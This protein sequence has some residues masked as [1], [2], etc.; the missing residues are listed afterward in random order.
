[1]KT[2]ATI[3]AVALALNAAVA[4]AGEIPTWKVIGLPVTPHQLAV[5]GSLQVQER[6]PVR[7]L[8]LGGMPASPHQIAVLT[9]RQAAARRQGSNLFG[10]WKS[11]YP[12]RSN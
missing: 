4:S 11:P 8:S 3:A 7:T 10:G 1:V 2:L 5:V 12:A 9:P 6:P